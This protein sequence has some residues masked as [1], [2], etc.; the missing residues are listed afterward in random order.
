MLSGLVAR[1]VHGLIRGVCK[2][3][4]VELSKGRVSQGHVHLFVS[5]PPHLEI[6][7]LV[8]YIEG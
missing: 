1:R 7:N 2:E 6:S 8:Q 5:V 4:D 3:H